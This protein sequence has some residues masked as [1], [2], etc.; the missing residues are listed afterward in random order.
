[1]VQ[2]SPAPALTKEHQ[3]SASR[4]WT[5]CQGKTKGGPGVHHLQ[6]PTLEKFSAIFIG[7]EGAEEVHYEKYIMQ[8]QSLYTHSYIFECF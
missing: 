5:G 1:M 8:T 7:H 3:Q 2:G 6:D 4:T